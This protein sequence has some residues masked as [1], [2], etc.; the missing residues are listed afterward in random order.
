MHDASA[1]SILLTVRIE[2]S[3]RAGGYAR[4]NQKVQQE[5]GNQQ[6]KFRKNNT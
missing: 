6:W 4:A 5:I 1:Y 3:N 2:I